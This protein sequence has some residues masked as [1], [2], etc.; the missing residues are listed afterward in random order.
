MK[1]DSRTASVSISRIPLALIL[2][3]FISGF[4]FLSF[5]TIWIRTLTHQ[6]GGTA[7]SSAV[8]ISVFFAFA[9][10]GNLWASRA[11]RSCANPLRLY[12]WCEVICA[13]FAALFFAVRPWIEPI[14]NGG[15][16]LESSAPRH[17]AYAAAILAIPSFFS[18][19]TFPFRIRSQSAATWIFISLFLDWWDRVSRS[20]YRRS[21]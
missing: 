16:G 14:M 15:M 4:C 11:V 21:F 13:L 3:Y 19:A 6:T 8:I 1:R 2:V 10:L 12:G 20:I 18:G 17:F 7:F 5:E 9:A